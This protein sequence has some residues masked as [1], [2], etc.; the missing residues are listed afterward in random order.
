MESRRDRESRQ[1]QLEELARLVCDHSSRLASVLEE[2]GNG[3]AKT[4]KLGIACQLL[5][6][7]VKLDR[8]TR[9]VNPD[10]PEIGIDDPEDRADFEGELDLMNDVFMLIRWREYL[11]CQN[12]G[13]IVELQ[14]SIPSVRHLCRDISDID[15]HES[16]GFA[17]QAKGDLTSQHLTSRL[18]FPIDLEIELMADVELCHGMVGISTRHRPFS[19]FSANDVASIP[20]SGNSISSAAVILFGADSATLMARLR[21]RLLGL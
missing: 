12:R 16:F 8:M 18:G 19:Q 13:A 14:G 2:P 1:R 17:T 3:E 15:S 10:R 11:D 7:V 20:S 5:A 21:A 4:R 6:V 9:P